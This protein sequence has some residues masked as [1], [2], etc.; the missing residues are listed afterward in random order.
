MQAVVIPF[1]N[2]TSDIP[3]ATATKHLV[4]L[5]HLD[6]GGPLPPLP[7]LTRDDRKRLSECYNEI[8]TN[9]DRYTEQ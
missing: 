4:G 3:T 8:V 1:V 6:I 2:A 7:E 9:V 5:A